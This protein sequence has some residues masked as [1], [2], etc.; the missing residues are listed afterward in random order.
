MDAPL[1][2][3]LW[4]I[5]R[6]AKVSIAVIT[7]TLRFFARL[8]TY[9][10][11][12][13]LRLYR[14]IQLTKAVNNAS[15]G[16]QYRNTP[17]LLTVSDDLL[18]FIEL[19][20]SEA[21]NC[22]N[23]ARSICHFH[24]R[25]SHRTGCKSCTI[26]LFFNDTEEIERLCQRDFLSWHGSEAIYLGD[27]PTRVKFPRTGNNLCPADRRLRNPTYLFSAQRRV[28]ILSQHGG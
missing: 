27:M 5:Y 15:H 7:N 25:I 19:S 3:N 6:E 13:Q 16:V 14:V 28:D 11:A 1:P 4:N 17:E 2:G 8:T 26:A 23:T 10:Q 20:G 21:N 18:S 12:R 9:D 22:D 24:A